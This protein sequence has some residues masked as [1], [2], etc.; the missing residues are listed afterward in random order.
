M[1][2][3]L[4]IYSFSIFIILYLQ[5]ASGQSSQ[6]A[7][8]EQISI[9]DIQNFSPKDYGGYHSQNWAV[10]QDHR[11]VMYFGNGSGVLEYDGVFWR[12]IYTEKQMI[13]RSLATADNGR[14]YVGGKGEFGY[15]AADET[16]QFNYV[17]L[18]S[19][20]PEEVLDFRDVWDIIPAREG[21]Y[22]ITN[23][24]LFRWQPDKNQ[25]LEH[26]ESG[27][28]KYW[29]ANNRFHK[30]FLIRNTLYTR[31]RF[32]GLFKL[33]ADSLQ[34]LPGS[35]IFSRSAIFAMTAF[36][37]ANEDNGINNGQQLLVFTRS[38]GAFLFD[39]EKFTPYLQNSNIPE[40]SSTYRLLNGIELTDNNIALGTSNTGLIIADKAGRIIKV[41]NKD[42]GLRDQAVR[43][44]Y[45]DKQGGIWLALNNGIARIEYPAT[46]SFYQNQPFTLNNVN[47]FVRHNERLYLSTSY[48]I[49][50]LSFSD[51]A[52]DAPVL[53]PLFDESI[54]CWAL[55]SNGRSLLVATE[56]GIYES[57]NGQLTLL[58][59]SH[60][61]SIKQSRFNE[62][63]IFAG[64]LEGLQIIKAS[65]VGTFEVFT[66]D[67]LES[68]EVRS[69][70]EES[71]TVLWLGLY[72]KGF[73]RIEIPALKDLASKEGRYST[74]SDNSLSAKI[75]RFDR[76][77]RMPSNSGRAFFVDDRIVLATNRALKKYDPLKKRFFADSSWGPVFA[78]SMR[79]VTH[80]AERKPNIW[81]KTSSEEGRETFALT[82]NNDGSY[83]VDATT[84]N[85]IADWGSIYAI[86]PD[87]ASDAV[88]F[89]GPEGVV[90]YQPN[91]PKDYSI[92]F[93]AIVR[94]VT[95]LKNDTLIYGGTAADSS[96]IA[97]AGLSPSSPIINYADNSL[98]LEYGSP[99][100]DAIKQNRY[101]YMLDG[102]DEEWSLWT[103]E[104]KKEYT[105]LP[106]GNYTFQVQAKNVYEKLSTVGQFHFTVLPPWYRSWWAFLIYGVFAVGIIY[107]Y[108][109]W[110]TAK[111]KSQNLVLESLVMDRTEELAEKNLELQEMNEM[112]SRFF[113]NISHEF[114]TPLTL[115]LGQ[116]N[117]VLPNLKKP[118]NIDALQ[119][120]SRNASLLQKMINQLL[121]LSKLDA[122]KMVLQASEQNIVP[123]LK[124]LTSAFDSFAHQREIALMF[125]SEAENIPVYFEQNKLEKVIYNL[126][127]NALK[128]TE[129]GGK[130][131][132][133]VK[134]NQAAESSSSSDAG[135]V[136]IIVKDSGVG[137]PVDRLANIFD[138]F[139]QVDDSSTREFEGTGIGLALTKELVQIHGGGIDVQSEVDFGTTFTVHLPLGKAHLQ[140]AQIVTAA[141]PVET[142]APAEVATLPTPAPAAESETA[143]GASS[144]NDLVLIVEDNAD[145]RAYIGNTL[146]PHYNIITA[147][148]GEEGFEK[149]KTEVPDLIITDV[150]MPKVDGYEL[151]EKL[152]EEQ[153][154]SHI[155][156]IMLTAKAA[157]QDKFQGLETGADAFLVKPF[158]TEE[159]NIR[160]RKLIELRQLLRN[161]QGK[162]AA[163]EPLT[164]KMASLDQAFLEKLRSILKEN[165]TNEDFTSDHLAAEAGVSIRQ[166]QRKL[167]SLT[168]FSP[169][170]YIRSLRLQWAKQMLAQG[171]GNVTDAAF[172]IGY[173]TVSAFSKAFRAEFGVSPSDFLASLDK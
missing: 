66:I 9:P 162:K 79:F 149:A 137:I 46:F 5:V 128:F 138:R 171:A 43:K 40:M 55:S 77:H 153:M 31:E 115:I 78:D 163:F 150:M 147:V 169:H 63:L 36:P 161:E 61:R 38:R 135:E 91:L 140:P 117:H 3:K 69:I 97:I 30:I 81:V 20:F 88:W 76:R 170:Q 49:Y 10:T 125:K 157:E 100:Y 29:K 85:R 64:L 113:A 166:L 21:I 148:N 37:S 39:G 70:A 67:S 173:Q 134:E 133:E 101:R 89:G 26:P 47:N 86:Y 143:A 122:N 141:A 108:N 160:V 103:T 111:L 68:Y 83:E 24:Y 94:R 109:R 7:S 12:I 102:F 1:T 65:P 8:E 27:T 25:Q 60:T 126:L 124:Q 120:A 34:L 14:I 72:Q 164:V 13:V 112:K 48:N 110:R 118:D 54:R 116:I 52:P 146:M 131:L 62:N 154:T 11:G 121:D 151:T 172:S 51:N 75:E 18:L 35:E 73:I 152:R 159:L 92:D 119:M 42:A 15:L 50:E 41:I 139:Y 16:G 84:F 106:E 2:R 107:G 90:R 168:G 71:E 105:N 80:I 167:K 4:I 59:R 44:I 104:T 33:T 158:S 98:R 22:F 129:A 127:S 123:L 114:R 87:P 28:L 32:S 45:Q 58:S 144:Q 99:S 23:N 82:L 155:P 19:G 145:M 6:I 74:S 57:R 136:L 17:S 132:V 142:D 156:I 130:V 56:R 95:M 165:I 53:Q 96:G 93:P